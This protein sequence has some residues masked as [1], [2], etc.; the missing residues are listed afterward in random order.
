[1]FYVANVIKFSVFSELLWKPT[2]LVHFKLNSF[3]PPRVNKF[4][5]CELL[6]GRYARFILLDQMVYIDNGNLPSGSSPMS[7]VA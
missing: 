6:F 1:M 5:I 2:V 3:W 7:Q 4:D